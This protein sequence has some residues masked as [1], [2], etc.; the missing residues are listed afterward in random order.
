MDWWHFIVSKT[1]S[2]YIN[3]LSNFIYAS[4]GFLIGAYPRLQ[5]ALYSR[6]IKRIWTQGGRLVI[7]TGTKRITKKDGVYVR[8]GDFHAAT[9]VLGFVR[10]KLKGI[11]PELYVF[12]T[13]GDFA[14]LQD[15][16]LVL[17]GGPH[18]NEVT[19]SALLELEKQ[20]RLPFSFGNYFFQFGEGERFELDIQRD[21]AILKDYAVI[22]KRKN[23][24]NDQ[25]FLIL[26]FGLKSF[27]T[28]AAAR[29]LV[30]DQMYSHKSDVTDVK[31]FCLLIGGHVSDDNLISFGLEHVV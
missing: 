26:L 31:E 3:V 18:N 9:E 27:G 29:F 13:A 25:K 12:Q 2:V 23:P 7:F 24:F 15:S 28:L 20:Q 30:R 10:S 11:E 6:R 1:E 16:N 5:S 22:L 8:S 14:A 4:I 17:I 21:G 19:N